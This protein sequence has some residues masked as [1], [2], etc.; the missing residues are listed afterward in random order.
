MGG[1]QQTVLKQRAEDLVSR[2]KAAYTSFGGKCR[3]RN[4]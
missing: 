4:G 2:N 1:I 3:V